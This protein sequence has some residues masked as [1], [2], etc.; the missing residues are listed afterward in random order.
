MKKLVVNFS[1]VSK[2][3]I[4]LVGGK[5]SSLGEL[6]RTNIPVPEGFAVT[7][8]A[9][10]SFIKEN[11]LDEF[12]VNAIKGLD[13]DDVIELKHVSDEIREKI[14]RGKF[15]LDLLN[16]IKKNYDQLC[17]DS[18]TPIDVAV[19]SSATAEDLP[20]ASFA[21]QQDT[22]L[23][24]SDINNLLKRIKQCFSSLYTSRAIV[25]RDEHNIDHHSVLMSVGIQKMIDSKS[26]GV[27][28]TI[29]PIDGD[30]NL[31]VIESSWGVGEAIVQGHVVP[32][33]FVIKKH[34]LRI[35]E[36][37]IATKDK[38]IKKGVNTH[39][40]I[41]V[42]QKQSLSSS[43]SDDD[44][45]NLANYAIKI[46]SHY[47]RSMDIE[48][49]IDDNEK[50][51]ILQARPETVWHEKL[52]A[53]EK[54]DYDHSKE[55]LIETHPTILV[56]GLGASPGHSN[57]K[58]RIINDLADIHKFQEDEIL[59]TEMTSPDWVPAMKKAAA[60]VTDSGGMTAHAAIVSRELGVPCIVGTKNATTALK[61]KS[62]V[63]V[64]GSL[65]HVY[66]GIIEDKTSKSESSVVQDVAAPITATKI[67]MNLGQPEKISEYKDLP[68]D[69]IGLMRIEFIIAD[70]IG[71]HPISMIQNKKQD[72]FVDKLSNSI[73]SVA[74]AIYPKPIVVRFSDFKTNE[75]KLLKGGETFEPIE[76]NPMIGWRG[77]SRY[78][79][80]DY[81][82]A[83]R[84]E[85]KAIKKIRDHMG[86]KN[87]WVMIPFARTVDE[88]KATLKIM[89]E[90]GLERD[91]DFKIWLMI[92][93]PSQVF[94]A[95]TF[96]Q[97]CD[98]FSIGSNDLTQLILGVDRDSAI[99]G[100]LGYFDERDEAVSK[101]IE[102]IIK[103]A[104]RNNI[105][106]S[107]CGQAPSVFP[108][109]TEFLINN[110]IDSISVNPD[111]VISTRKL[112]ASVEQKIILSKLNSVFQDH[113]NDK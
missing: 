85:C 1:E 59:V 87:V 51:Y 109:F 21:G 62:M 60:I 73:S 86:L 68:S 80:P 49:A 108:E 54:A 81:Q 33:R 97:L 113:I 38:M 61:N 19:R 111:V 82:D 15:S 28:F 32:D 16:E 65:G 5:V 40:E 107:I 96:S 11:N 52:E 12:V 100:G 41:E 22:F 91:K 77:V 36:R 112:V 43:L 34:P 31:I 45:I 18:V 8:F 70:E 25:Y 83:F 57:G 20:D 104:K 58:I 53:L 69:G 84:L 48:W 17:S 78:I 106:V 9:F 63:T 71:E 74:R 44:L 110:G 27:L 76:A 37:E 7:S 10:E 4:D 89:A 13:F 6:I 35:V 101:A 93:I 88:V 26:S 94:L 14:E 50:I 102:I 23:Y 42:P 30:K 3:D 47:N 92:E 46:E 90:E 64:N 95:D 99:L 39:V 66:K 75:Y 79:D 24:V 103:S 67:Y 55:E 2:N 72:I 29:N 98:G 105:T 56:S